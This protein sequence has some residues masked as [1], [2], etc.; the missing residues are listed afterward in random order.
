MTNETHQQIKAYDIRWK[1]QILYIYTCII[2]DWMQFFLHN[3]IQ[4]LLNCFFFDK[5]AN[6]RVIVILFMQTKNLFVCGYLCLFILAGR[7]LIHT[8]NKQLFLDLSRTI[9]RFAIN[10]FLIHSQCSCS[11]FEL[12]L[13]RMQNEAQLEE[14][15]G[16]KGWSTIAESNG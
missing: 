16:K 15:E 2:L 13:T 6:V 9:S 11:F 8:L 5:Q 1:N 12:N 7:L 14:F 10:H 3:H 4:I